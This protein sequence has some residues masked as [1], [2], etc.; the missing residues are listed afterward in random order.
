MNVARCVPG[1]VC[2]HPLGLCVFVPMG[3]CRSFCTLQCMC[4]NPNVFPYGGWEF[5]CMC[6][7]LCIKTVVSASAVSGFHLK[8]G[9]EQSGRALP[10]TQEDLGS[11]LARGT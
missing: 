11:N 9:G 1:C 4:V 10:W 2:A 6:M 5:V 3:V 8:H 7:H